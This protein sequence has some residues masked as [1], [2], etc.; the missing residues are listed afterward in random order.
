MTLVQVTLRRSSAAVKPSKLAS[1]NM[2][3]VV[4]DSTVKEVEKP[5]A[6]LNRLETKTPFGSQAQNSSGAT[7][8]S[9]Y[10][11]IAGPLTHVNGKNGYAVSGKNGYVKNGFHTSVSGELGKVRSVPDA[12][13]LDISP[14]AMGGSPQ[15]APRS[16][17]ALQV[18]DSAP[19]GFSL[20]QPS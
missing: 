4:A 14:E 18:F 11:N 15:L 19:R 8:H 2:T 10:E 5:S 12:A 20:V 1:K 17:E 9:G 6:R 16:Y 13:I 7:M 3:Y